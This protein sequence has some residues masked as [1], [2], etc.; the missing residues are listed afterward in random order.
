MRAK[1]SETASGLDAWQRPRSEPEGWCTCWSRQRA[2]R[3]VS[4]KCE[5][6]GP[7]GAWRSATSLTPISKVASAKRYGGGDCRVLAFRFGVRTKTWEQALVTEMSRTLERSRE[8]LAAGSR[9]VRA[10]GYAVRHGG[11]VGVA[12]VLA[13]DGATAEELLGGF[14]PFGD[15]PGGDYRQIGVTDETVSEKETE[16]SKLTPPSAAAGRNGSDGALCQFHETMELFGVMAQRTLHELTPG[17]CASYSSQALPSRT[18]AS[19]A[20][21]SA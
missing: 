1:P 2:H 19:N 21:S 15:T 4:G 16:S 18:R 5:L 13:P 3:R 10:V 11:M 9:V 6:V 14:D 8:A 7:S 12:C 17:Y 20:W